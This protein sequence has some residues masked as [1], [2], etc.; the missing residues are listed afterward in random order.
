MTSCGT[1]Q[2]NI[3]KKIEQFKKMTQDVNRDNPR[4]VILAQHLYI[5]FVRKNE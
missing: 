3:P 2:I 1:A 4:E 5:N